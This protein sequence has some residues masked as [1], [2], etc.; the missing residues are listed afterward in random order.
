MDF[1]CSFKVWRT[2]WREL[3]FFVWMI[4]LFIWNHEESIQ[5]FWILL[6]EIIFNVWSNVW[7]VVADGFQD[8]FLSCFSED[9]FLRG[10]QVVYR[11]SIGWIWRNVFLSE[12]SLFS[13]EAFL[14]LVVCLWRSEEM[15]LVLLSLVGTIACI[16]PFTFNFEVWSVTCFSKLLFNDEIVPKELWAIVELAKLIL[17]LLVQIS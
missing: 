17:Y 12:K 16:I 8:F 2:V 7:I 13:G 15:F 4:V 1:R 3:W 11:W 9:I 5:I 10:D 14:G 6:W